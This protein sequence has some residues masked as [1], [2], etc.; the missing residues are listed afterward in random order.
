MAKW[1]GN[2]HTVNTV[3]VFTLDEL[4]WKIKLEPGDMLEVIGGQVPYLDISRNLKWVIVPEDRERYL[5][6]ISDYK[7]M[8]KERWDYST[9]MLAIDNPYLDNKL[10]KMLYDPYMDGRVRIYPLDAPD[11]WVV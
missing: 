9:T 6:V 5:I 4:R 3:N 8:D 7:Q 2:G 11:S 10:I 1:R